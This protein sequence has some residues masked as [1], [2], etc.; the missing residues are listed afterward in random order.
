M[1]KEVRRN[2]S[3][4]LA[5]FMVGSI[6]LGAKYFDDIIA[7]S[8]GV[9]ASNHSSNIFEVSSTSKSSKPCPLM[10]EVQRDAISSP[11]KGN[12]ITNND[13]NALNYYNGTVW[14]EVGEGAGGGNLND[15][16]D[17]VL[18]TPS[19]ND[20]LT[21]DLSSSNW[22]NSVL[23][24]QSLVGLSDTTIAVPSNN[25]VLTYNGS[26]WVNA[27]PLVLDVN[28][29]TGNVVLDTD[30][31]NEGVANL[32]HTIARVL[33]IFSD[34][35]ENK[36]LDF[37]TASNSKRLTIP[38]N[39]KTNLTALTRK[40]GSLVYA[41]DEKK[42]FIDDGTDL[43]EIGSG[44]SGQGELNYSANPY[45]IKDL[46]GVTTS[47]AFKLSFLRTE[48]LS[49]IQFKSIS[50]GSLKIFKAGLN[51]KDAYIKLGSIAIDESY[52]AQNLAVVKVY[53][54][55]TKDL[56]FVHES[57]EVR[58]VNS[59]G[60]NIVVGEAPKVQAGTAKEYQ[61]LINPL[62]VTSIDTRLYSTTTDTTAYDF[63]IGKHVVGV[64]GQVV[65]DGITPWQD[66]TVTGTFTNATY[67]AKRR[68]VG[69]NAEYK[70][71]MVMTGAP[72]SATLDLTLPIGDVIDVN[73][74]VEVQTLQ[75]PIMGSQSKVFDSGTASYSV[76]EIDYVNTT[77]VRPHYDIDTT[78]G[79]SRNN[80]N[81]SSPFTWASGDKGWFYF[82]VPLTRLPISNTLTNYELGLQSSRVYARGNA[83][84][85]VTAAN[86]IPFITS[87]DI[88]GSWSG[89][90]FT[91]PKTG[92]YAINGFVRTSSSVS[93]T[94]YSYVNG[95]QDK[96]AST[97]NVTT[98]ARSF[99]WQGRLN[100]GDIWDVRGPLG[101]IQLQNG[102]ATHWL[103]I[104]HVPDFTM[105]NAISDNE[106][107]E[108]HVDTG[109]GFGSTNTRV[110][111]YSQVR[112]NT[113]G[114]WATFTDSAA[115][116]SYVT[117]HRPCKISVNIA[118]IRSG[119]PGI[120]VV[121]N[122]T[123][124]T[125]DANSVTYA[126]GQRSYTAGQT[127]IALSNSIT[128]NVRANDTVWV[129]TYEVAGYAG[130]NTATKFYINIISGSY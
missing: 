75:T 82:S 97:I 17:V 107:R 16:G 87:S 4:M 72:A 111:R 110:R 31:I 91:A 112:K 123:A 104:S 14:K 130:S 100:K 50:S 121:L 88:F 15:L 22:V 108:L 3:I 36:D 21:Y 55:T 120:A 37:G 116:G 69:K 89:T 99:T 109:N 79:I 33:S 40:E 113:L 83:G 51:T 28:T 7:E 78:S 60:D 101:S 119:V 48:D 118:D 90:R 39:T 85:N 35:A 56:N 65:N 26:A 129:Q 103:E 115:L 13:T 125:T 68:Y 45:F 124:P 70:V 76:A 29:Q 67:A 44:G 106:D 41:T 49:E 27:S 43:V 73:E 127:G 64:L 84:Q 59:T 42:A 10:T 8:V 46:T 61:V 24:S 11:Q 105:Y 95:I 74:M 54:D 34:T 77:T 53:L 57:F 117:F 128:L 5:V 96:L 20:Y 32:Y 63:I 47:D 98:D 38:K 25:E 86:P 92:N 6:A 114:S 58:V 102:T 12:C 18:T 94:L 52:Q 126:Q 71:S 80:I 9:G 23:P 2:L 66:V 1:T 122:G 19:D 81:Q 62:G 93:I 30:D